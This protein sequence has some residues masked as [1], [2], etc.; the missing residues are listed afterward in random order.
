MTR[1]GGFGRVLLLKGKGRAR[2]FYQAFPFY[3]SLSKIICH[4]GGDGVLGVMGWVRSWE[5]LDHCY[6][7]LLGLRGWD[8]SIFLFLFSSFFF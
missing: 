4:A 5:L 8:V 6:D 3:Q 1:R 2:V 7:Y